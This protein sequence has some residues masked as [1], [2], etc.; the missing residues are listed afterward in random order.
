M[1]G[2]RGPA[3][4]RSPLRDSGPGV[5]VETATPRP[6]AAAAGAAFGALSWLRG[7]RIFHPDGVGYTGILRIE[8]PQPEHAV[9]LLARPGDHPALIRF[10]RAAGVPEPLPDALGLSLRLVD[11][12]GRG[13]HQDFL[14]VT[15]ADGPLLHHLVLPGVRG[16]FGHSFSSLLPYR[17]G[18]RLRLVGA[19]P[20]RQ[21][22][23]LARGALAEL[24]ELAERGN[25]HFRF[26]LAS[27]VGGW[28]AVGDLHVAERLS[29]DETERLAFT[30]WNTGGGIRPVGPLMG[31][32]KAAYRA[33]QRARGLHPSEI[34]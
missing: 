28:S 14:L 8:R 16:F 3:A 20:A 33:S 25:L 34:P 4:E 22:E 17:L 24:V 15:S 31:L 19:Q 9:P 2:Q 11:V 13:R 10:S 26:A 32:R 21:R 5:A 12:H 1:D 7:A 23:R 30:P 18:G 29:R 6:L 27:L